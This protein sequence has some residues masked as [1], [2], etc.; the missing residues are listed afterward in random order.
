[1][2]ILL[3]ACALKMDKS[4][5][6]SFG[7]DLQKS[8]NQLHL[9]VGTKSSEYH[10]L[11]LHKKNLNITLKVCAESLHG[12]IT[13]FKT[14]QDIRYGQN[15]ISYTA[16]QRIKVTPGVTFVGLETSIMHVVSTK[17]I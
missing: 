6:L 5:S 13:F 1:M 16:E 7:V 9:L 12:S 15:I 17:L 14:K 4:K 8:N 2:F 11:C 3:S 10:P